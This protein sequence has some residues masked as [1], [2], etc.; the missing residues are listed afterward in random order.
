MGDRHDE[1]V[2]RG[3]IQPATSNLTAGDWRKFTHI[4]VPDDVDPLAIL[5][6][7]RKDER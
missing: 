6:Q 3:V 5:F 1:L 7:M 4:E 2:A